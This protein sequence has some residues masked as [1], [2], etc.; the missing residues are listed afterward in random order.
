VLGPEP[1]SAAQS[2]LLR[3]HRHPARVPDARGTLTGGALLS[4]SLGEQV[5]FFAWT[6]GLSEL[7]SEFLSRTFAR[8]LLLVVS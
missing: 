3:K 8:W 2:Q 4:A 6:A 1:A 7:D 5:I